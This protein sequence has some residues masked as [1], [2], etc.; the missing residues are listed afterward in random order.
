MLIAGKPSMSSGPDRPDGRVAAGHDH[1]EGRAL[2]ATAA[3]FQERA[4]ALD[5]ADPL[6][7]FRA[8]FVE[9]DPALVYLDGNSLGRL[10][11]ATA[12]RLARRIREEWGGE[13]VR[14]WDHWLDEPAR[15]GEI[16]G[17][18]IVGARPGETI[19]S[20]STTVNLYKLAR[21]GARCP[22]RPDRDRRRPTTS[23][24]PTATCSRVWPRR[25]G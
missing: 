8:H 23:S 12:D 5:A 24:R 2:T 25:A 18:G 11:R 19:V 15:V 9:D 20:D 1:E 10:P 7:G 13:L 17:T 16:I 4:R 6:A 14:G 22:P 3:T 21:G